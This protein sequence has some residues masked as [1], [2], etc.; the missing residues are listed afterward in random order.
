[1]LSRVGKDGYGHVQNRS[2]STP[3]SPLSSCLCRIVHSHAGYSSSALATGSCFAFSKF[4]PF[5]GVP[6]GT[7]L[8]TSGA[9]F[10]SA[11]FAAVF[12]SAG[13][14]AGVRG[15]LKGC[16]AEVEVAAEEAPGWCGVG[17]AAE[18]MGVAL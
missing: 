5:S 9:A 2:P 10:F 12:S 4:R 1:M 17:C 14:G 6:A 15:A 7:L 8:L 11:T 3:T 18:E 13:L 16:A